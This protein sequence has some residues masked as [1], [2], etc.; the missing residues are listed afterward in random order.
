MKRINESLIPMLL[1]LLMGLMAAGCNPA[2]TYEEE[3]KEKIRN[4]LD[5]HPDLDFE[6]KPSGL[7]YFEEITG[8]GDLAETHDTAY[9]FYTGYLTDGYKFDTN[10]ET[11]GD[12]IDTLVRPVN[13][14]WFIKG[15]DEAITYMRV[16]GKSTVLMPSNLAYY[17]YTP[18]V[19]E[20]Q[21]VKLVKGE[22][23]GGR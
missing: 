9:L 4:F 1:V 17:D 16:G 2:K 8:T 6:L 3:Q 12:L 13:E 23:K 19:F 22:G 11:N 10:I 20:I 18:L 7:Y 21:L 15:F 14:G 5:S